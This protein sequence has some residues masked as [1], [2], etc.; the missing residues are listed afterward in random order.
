MPNKSTVI[1]SILAASVASAALAQ[2]ADTVVATVG[3]TD[4]TLGEMVI[5]RAQL[6]QQYQS[7]PDDVLFEGVLE[8]LIQ[9]QLLADS[10]GEPTVRV[11]LAIRNERRSLM[12]GEA[13]DDITTAAVTDEA[14]QA[15]YDAA[16]ADQPPAT[17]YRASHLLVATEDEAIAAKARIDAGE[18]FAAVATDVSTDGSSANGGDL[19]WFGDGQMVAEFE[20]MVKSLEPG[21][22]SDPFQTQ[23]GWHVVTLVETREQ[24]QP[25]LEEVRGQL[26]QTLQADAIAARIEE[27]EA[28][29]TVVRPEAGAFDPAVLSDLSLLEPD[30]E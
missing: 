7:L 2:D 3:D 5:V 18:D 15:A 24:A 25:T 20:E 8:Q 19:G 28:E 1:A 21:A 26:S 22:V 17:E 14:L 23:F 9:Q 4:I 27:L 30:A 29:A 13:V 6:P 10:M 11:E 16:Y 12:A